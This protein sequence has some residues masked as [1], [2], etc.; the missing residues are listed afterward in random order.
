MKISYEKAAEVLGKT[1][2]LQVLIHLFNCIDE[3]DY[4]SG[5]ANATKLSHSSVSRVASPLLEAGVLLERKLGKQI[6]IFWINPSSETAQKT[7]EYFEAVFS[8]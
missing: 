3:E 8:D 4:L 1:A 5:I 2:Q 6:R 7:R